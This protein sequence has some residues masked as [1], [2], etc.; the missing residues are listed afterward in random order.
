MSYMFMNNNNEKNTLKSRVPIYFQTKKNTNINETLN[1]F[2]YVY[3][4][5][6]RA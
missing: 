1:V 6:I 4:V 3:Q 2:N 5:N